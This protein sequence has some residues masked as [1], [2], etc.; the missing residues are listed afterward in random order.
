MFKSDL[1]FGQESISNK[2]KSVIS[3]FNFKFINLLHMSKCHICIGN[4]M[5]IVLIVLGY[6]HVK[7]Y[8]LAII[9]IV[10]VLCPLKFRGQFSV[11]LSCKDR[12]SVYSAMRINN[13]LGKILVLN[14]DIKEE[15]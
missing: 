4:Y 7:F 8:Y 2:I 14:T 12:L 13:K 9:I 3:K 6:D 5:N 10:L 1:W 11:S 15:Q